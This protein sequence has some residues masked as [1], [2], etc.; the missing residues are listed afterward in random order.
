MALQS[1]TR[2]IQL[3]ELGEERE[4]ARNGSDE[5]GVTQHEAVELGEAADA[6]GDRSVEGLETQVQREL[7][8]GGKEQASSAFEGSALPFV[9]QR[10]MRRVQSLQ[11][12]KTL[13][14]AKRH[15]VEL[16]RQVAHVARPAAIHLAL[17]LPAPGRHQTAHA[18]C[19][20]GAHAS[21][22]SKHVGVASQENDV[23]NNALWQR[24]VH[25]GL[26][27]AQLVGRTRRRNERQVQKVDVRLDVVLR[28]TERPRLARLGI[29]ARGLLG[30]LVL[31]KRLPPA[32]RH[33]PHER[34]QHPIA[35]SHTFTAL[36]QRLNSPQM[37]TDK[38]AL[39]RK[40][41]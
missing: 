26:R 40:R 33:Q 37:D 22:D 5:P 38:S 41:F 13:R 6:V 11:D 20:V 32:S 8:F 12:D 24:L 28:T 15:F 30:R 4:T 31:M 18:D 16:M 3:D 36:P 19:E 10:E 21:D 17:E 29:A 39:T 25:A 35:S 9:G 2:K 34:S 1:I 23:V 7:A 27:L 14:R